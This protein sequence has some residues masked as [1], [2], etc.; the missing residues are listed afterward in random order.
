MMF[1]EE[2]TIALISSWFANEFSEPTTLDILQ[3]AIYLF[4]NKPIKK[5]GTDCGVSF[6][7]NERRLWN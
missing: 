2:D 5:T 3:N 6:N 1:F 4:N 7:L